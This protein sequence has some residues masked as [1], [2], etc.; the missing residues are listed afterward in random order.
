MGVAQT[1]RVELLLCLGGEVALSDLSVLDV[2]LLTL[3]LRVD[4]CPLRLALL[5]DALLCLLCLARGALLTQLLDLKLICLLDHCALHRIVFSKLE[6]EAIALLR[7]LNLLLVS[8]RGE[9]KVEEVDLALK[10][11]TLC[12]FSGGGLGLCLTPQLCLLCRLG[13]LLSEALEVVC[14]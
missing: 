4:D 8:L 1:Q 3:N 5:A 14:F 7:H 2:E 9:L 10:R 12:G 13:A 11:E 6:P